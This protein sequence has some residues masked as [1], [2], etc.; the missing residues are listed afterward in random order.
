MEHWSDEV[1]EK[2]LH[3][4]AVLIK[5]LANYKPDGTLNRE[6]IR[7]IQFVLGFYDA[8]LADTMRKRQIM[9]TVV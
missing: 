6:D 5:K 7:T 8:Q 1:I 4:G 9:N 3:D 2:A